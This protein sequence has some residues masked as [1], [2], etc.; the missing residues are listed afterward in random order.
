MCINLRAPRA[1]KSLSG[2]RAPSGEFCR[3][4][5]IS[6]V[7]MAQNWKNNKYMKLAMESVIE[8]NREPEKPIDR[9]KVQKAIA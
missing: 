1:R 4:K 8:D 9:E 2:Q 7:T 5:L 3:T 6:G